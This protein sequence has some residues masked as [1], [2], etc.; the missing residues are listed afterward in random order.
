MNTAV[1]DVKCMLDILIGKK[2]YRADDFNVFGKLIAWHLIKM[3]KL[4]M[5]FN[6]QTLLRAKEKAL[7][8]FDSKDNEYHVRFLEDEN[9]NH[10]FFTVSTHFHC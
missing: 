10:L 4:T 9:F 3:S 5:D 8:V 7:M 6:F 1:L 2:V